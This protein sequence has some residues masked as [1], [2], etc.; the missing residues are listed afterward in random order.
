VEAE[1]EELRQALEEGKEATQKVR[2]KK[3]ASRSEWNR[4]EDT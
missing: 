1:R 4:L 3:T 2:S